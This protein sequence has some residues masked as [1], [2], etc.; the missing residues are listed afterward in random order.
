[1]LKN[2]KKPRY[3]I[4]EAKENPVHIL[5][6]SAVIELDS[7]YMICLIA[8]LLVSQY[9]GFNTH[10]NLY[11]EDR[12]EAETVEVCRNKKGDRGFV[13]SKEE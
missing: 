12:Q 2:A 5:K 1:M 9:D 4:W 10:L 3:Y 13:T 11:I 7:L 6:D 8:K